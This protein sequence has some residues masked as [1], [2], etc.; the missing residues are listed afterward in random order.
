MFN[1]VDTH[2]KEIIK[3][4]FNL[5]PAKTSSHLIFA[6]CTHLL[7]RHPSLHTLFIAF[8]SR[9]I[10]KDDISWTDKGFN[11]WL[12]FLH[13]FWMDLRQCAQ[14][15]CIALHIILNLKGTAIVTLTTNE[16]GLLSFASILKIFWCF[17]W[18]SCDM[19]P[20]GFSGHGEISK[21]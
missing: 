10:L 4:K 19:R 3:I 1:T 11:T 18:E 9:V 14:K 6:A 7:C 20:N 21:N 12:K 16:E 5:I 2:I 8:I 17:C 15:L 13:L